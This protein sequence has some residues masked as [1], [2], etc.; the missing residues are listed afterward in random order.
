MIK[1]LYCLMIKEIYN[2]KGECYLRQG[3]IGSWQPIPLVNSG[4]Q[5]QGEKHHSSKAHE[6]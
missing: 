3:V 5:L 1:R 4:H 2:R 6:P